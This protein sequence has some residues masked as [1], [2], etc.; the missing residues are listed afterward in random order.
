MNTKLL[1]PVLTLL[2][3]LP[4][5]AATRTWDGGDATANMTAAA[6]WNGNTV[7][8]PAVDDL[9]FPLGLA[10]ADRT[11]N[12]NYPVNTIFKAVDFYDGGYT[13]NGTLLALTGGLATY[14]PT[15]TV[16]I[17]AGFTLQATQYFAAINSGALRGQLGLRGTLRPLLLASGHCEGP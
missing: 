5:T 7:I 2:A 12:N 1:T 4:A 13:L 15:G 16:T 17:N 14:H 3:A 10:L 11:V 6:N 9:D 8:N